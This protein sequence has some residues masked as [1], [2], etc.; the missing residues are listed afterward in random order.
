MKEIVIISGKG[1]TGKTSVTASLAALAENSVLAD[2]DVDAADLHILMD[3][4]IDREHEFYSGRIAET[5][6]SGCS[7]CGTCRDLCRF[8]AVNDDFSI[9]PVSCEGCNVCVHFCPEKV[10][11]LKDKMTGKWF[12]AASEYGPLYYARLNA[13]EDNSGKLVSQVKNSARIYTRDNDMDYLIIDGP[14]GIGCPVIASITG[15]SLVLIVTEPTVSGIHD[16]KRIIELAEHFKI[17]AMVCINKYDL[18]EKGTLELESY[19]G[20]K[21]IPVAGKISFDEVFTA[22]MIA[23]LPVV[24]YSNGQISRE[25][26]ALWQKVREKLET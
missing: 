3:P 9:D 11:T 14:P 1:G 13:A 5:D 23:R 4:V 21:N 26:R 24:R 22:A 12:E 17:P 7:L 19:C 20:V 2:C 8:D 25:L 10:I 16:L 6:L 18:S 15:A